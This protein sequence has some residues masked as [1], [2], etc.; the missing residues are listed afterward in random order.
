MIHYLKFYLSFIK[1]SIIKELEFR[2]NFI[3]NL[4]SDFLWLAVG[5]FTIDVLFTQLK[6]IGGWSKTDVQLLLLV[7]TF[8]V[9]VLWFFTLEKLA[10]FSELIQKGELDFILTKPLND[11]FLVS[12]ASVP[13]LSL[14]QMIKQLTFFSLIIIMVVLF[15]LPVSLLQWTQFFF[16][17]IV[18]FMIFYCLG[19]MIT[20][21]NIWV[22]KLDNVHF[23]LDHVIDAGRHPMS[24][25]QGI[26]KVIF[27]WF[28]PL[29]FTAHFATQ[30]LLSPVWQGTN[31]VVGITLAGG[32]FIASEVF[33]RYAIRH[34]ASASS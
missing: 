5:L 14:S 32:L 3:V 16:F 25:W 4:I 11:R 22:V 28:I 6:T 2:A 12:F 30:A 9:N 29:G 34:Y 23:L 31:I 15:L 24:I 26:A 10:Y 20:T 19:F 13:D 18:G 1:I 7:N 21:F 33:W 17:I 8:F 27:F